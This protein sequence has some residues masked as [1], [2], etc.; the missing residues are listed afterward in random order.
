MFR[1]FLEQK[2]L[3]ALPKGERGETRGFATFQNLPQRHL[4]KPV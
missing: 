4:D 1:R 2:C 3:T